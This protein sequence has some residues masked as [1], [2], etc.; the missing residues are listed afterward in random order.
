MLLCDEDLTDVRLERLIEQLSACSLSNVLEQLRVDGLIA[1]QRPQTGADIITNRYRHFFNHRFHVDIVDQTNEAF[2]EVER[3]ETI[4]VDDRPG[5]VVAAMRCFYSDLSLDLTMPDDL[6]QVFD[7]GSEQL[8]NVTKHLRYLESADL[9]L[10]RI[11]VT[12]VKGTQLPPPLP[13]SEE[14][15]ASLRK[16][17]PK[18]KLSGIPFD[19]FLLAYSI[20]QRAVLRGVYQVAADSNIFGTSLEEIKEKL[21]NSTTN[22]DIEWALQEMQR[23]VQLVLVGVD[24]DRYVTAANGQC[25]ILNGEQGSFFAEPWTTLNGD[26][27]PS[28]VR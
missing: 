8:A 1:K 7:T 18:D 27:N 16:I 25:W 5:M 10:E 13:S 19:D 6:L 17:I 28:T 11:K 24:C 9:H 3:C 15:F 22:E 12:P 26:I 4:T 20:E 14:I 23:E 2:S 21:A